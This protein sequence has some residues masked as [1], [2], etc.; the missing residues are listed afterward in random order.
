MVPVRS[1]TFLVFPINLWDKVHELG[2]GRN[3]AYFNLM[4][5]FVLLGLGKVENCFV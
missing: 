4:L 1:G 2:N 3:H 5:T